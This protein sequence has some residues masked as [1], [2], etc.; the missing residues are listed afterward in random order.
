MVPT[1]AWR[2]FAFVSSSL[3]FGEKLLAT[4]FGFERPR[5]GQLPRLIEKVEVR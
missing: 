4:V 2:L 5:M 3:N 1:A